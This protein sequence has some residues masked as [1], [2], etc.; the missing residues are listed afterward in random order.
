[1][2]ESLPRVSVVIINYNGVDRLEQTLHAV[3][4]LAYPEVAEVV[5]VDD[6][7][8]DGSQ[9]LVRERF[10]HIRLVELGQNQGAAAARNRALAEAGSELIFLLDNDIVVEPDCLSHLVRAK[11]KVP[12]AGAVHPTIIDQHDPRLSAHYNGGF[13]HYLCAYIPK[14]QVE[15][16]HAVYDVVSGGALLLEKSLAERIGGFD[17]AYVFNWEDGDFLFRLTLTG[18]PCL[19]V[20]AA[21]VTHTA[22]PRGTSKAFFQVRNRWFF[23]IKMYGWRTIALSA[24]ALIVFECSQ[25]L[26]LLLK[27]AG[28]EYVTGTWAAAR[29]L[30]ELLR[31]RRAVHL[32][33]VA[34]DRDVLRSGDLYVPPQL[35]NNPV[36]RVFKRAYVGFFNVYWLLIRKFV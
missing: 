30:P 3:E 17:E 19:N 7:S 6:G 12:H 24:P 32:L 35:L 29:Q 33:K 26:F 20:T 36:L 18:R 5:V 14:D 22:A 4:L 13:I 34:H 16:D 23:I 31:K 9:F 2:T 27:G 8:S 11:Q 28:K 15:E 21:K 1:M 25:F 10:P